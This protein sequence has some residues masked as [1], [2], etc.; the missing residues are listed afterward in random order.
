VLVPVDIYG[1]HGWI[2]QGL[3]KKPEPDRHIFKRFRAHKE[4]KSNLI[5][6]KKE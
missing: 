5:A 2:L 4:E 6:M 3:V 1:R